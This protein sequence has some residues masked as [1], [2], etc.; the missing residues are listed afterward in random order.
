MGKEKFYIVE[1]QSD[2]GV[3]DVEVLLG[4]F[5]SRKAANWE[6][7]KYYKQH[8]SDSEDVEFDIAK[9]RIFMDEGPYGRTILVA[10]GCANE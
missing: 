7:V 5:D 1:V 9:N 10:G 8:F 3:L 2:G 6:L 4:P